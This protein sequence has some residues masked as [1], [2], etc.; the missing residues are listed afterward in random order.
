MVAAADYPRHAHTRRQ[1]HATPTRFRWTDLAVL[2]IAGIV[3]AWNLGEGSLASSDDA[4]YAQMAREMAE[5]GRWAET[6]WLGT[7]V[8]EKPPLLLWLL[9]LSGETFGW[10]TLAM[11]LPGYLAGLL[12]LVYA[13]RLARH[14]LEDVSPWAPAFSVA[15]AVSTVTFTMT[16]RRPLTDPLL[17]ASVLATLWYGSR[18]ACTGRYRPAVLLGIAGGLG[19]LAKSVALGPAALAVLVGLAWRQRWKQLALAAAVAL[20]VAAPWHVLMSLR[21]GA[22]FWEVYLGYH[23]AARAEASLVGGEGPLYYLETAWAEDGIVAVLLAV[24]LVFGTWLWYRRKDSCDA[25]TLGLVAWTAWITLAVLHVASTRLFHYL[26][27]VVPLAAVVTAATL[28]ARKDFAVVTGVVAAAGFAIGPVDPHLLDPDYGRHDRLLAEGPLHDLPAD[29]RL[30]VWE[31][32]DPGLVFSTGRPA[33]IWT[34]HEGFHSLQQSIDMMRRTGAVVWASP[35]AKARL[36]RSPEPVV[37]VAPGE[38]SAGLLAF[39]G[40]ARAHRSVAVET[41]EPTGHRIVRLGP[42]PGGP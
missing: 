20:L 23:V 8:F 31:D 1:P 41:F 13:M 33:Q 30:V 15:L 35:E 34:A 37:L 3:L 18:V 17:M 6:P 2:A 14:A 28:V 26:L 36:A 39:A 19:V 5:S 32:Y 10:T 4:I 7:V 40:E 22:T 42:L 11:R 21:H 29:V 16:V 12:A 9:R 38:R 27:P 25:L 24:G